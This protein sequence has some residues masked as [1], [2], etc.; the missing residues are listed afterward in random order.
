MAL[1]D[2]EKHDI[3][4][5]MSK[6]RPIEFWRKVRSLVEAGLSL[7][8]AAKKFGVSY[9]GV[10][11]RSALEGWKFHGRGRPRIIRDHADELGRVE[12]AKKEALHREAQAALEREAGVVTIDLKRAENLTHRVLATHSAKLKV[13]LSELVVQTAEDLRSPEVRPKDRALALASLR[14][15]CDRLYGWDREP[16]IGEMERAKHPLRMIDLDLIATPPEK[17]KE[18]ALAKLARENG[19]LETVHEGLQGG[20]LP[21][22]EHAPAGGDGLDDRKGDPNELEGEKQDFQERS[23]KPSE[24]T[25]THRN[26]KPELDA[27]LRPQVP[28]PSESQADKDGPEEQRKIILQNL[29]RLR[30]QWRGQ[31]R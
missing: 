29:A 28:L 17:L 12:L 1:P 10:Q 25:A 5:S 19:S 2:V 14:S 21:R 24:S 18:L 3:W 26:L 7:K 13:M 22:P 6:V 27:I 4:V 11:A 15:V 16:D 23:T 20:P 31:R 8:K 9:S 30:A